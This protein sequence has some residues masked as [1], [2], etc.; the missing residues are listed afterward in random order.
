MVG[1]AM[2]D[3]HPVNDGLLSVVVPLHGY[4]GLHC[5]L[6]DYL[7]KRKFPKSY[8]VGLWVLR[9]VSLAAV[10]GCWQLNTND[11]GVSATWRKVWRGGEPSEKE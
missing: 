2:L 11:I 4:W 3:S 10:Y 9:G 7:P 1:Y 5:V 6:T 8:Q